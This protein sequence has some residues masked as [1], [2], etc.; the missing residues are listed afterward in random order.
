MSGPWLGR[1]VVARGYGTWD[2]RAMPEMRLQEEQAA[3]EAQLDSLFGAHANEYVLFKG[4]KPV[5]FFPDHST[6]YAAAL[7]R[8]GVDATFLIAQVRKTVPL[9]VSLSWEAGVLVG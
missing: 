1:S 7:E 3:F 2:G 5:A 6:A 8:F 9:P 4:G